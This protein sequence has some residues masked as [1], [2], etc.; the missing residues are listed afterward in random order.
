MEKNNLFHFFSDVDDDDDDV[1]GD[2]MKGEKHEKDDK[3]DDVA[4]GDVDGGAIPLTPE[5]PTIDN[6]YLRAAKVPKKMKMD[7]I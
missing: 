3:G 7:T 6:P 1:D 5:T 2:N 4:G